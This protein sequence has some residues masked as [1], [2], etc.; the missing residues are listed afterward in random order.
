MGIIYKDE[1]KQSKTPP[2]F[3]LLAMFKALKM[4][5]PT[6]STGVTWS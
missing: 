3:S 1:V 5:I 4:Y 6:W 2:M